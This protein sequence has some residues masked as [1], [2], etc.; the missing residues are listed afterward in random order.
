MKYFTNQEK[1][2]VAESLEWVLENLGEDWVEVKEADIP[3]ETVTYSG[4][5]ESIYTK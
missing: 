3:K 1:I 4:F 2:V 5:V